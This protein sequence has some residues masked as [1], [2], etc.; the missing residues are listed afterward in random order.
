MKRF[1]AFLLIVVS[2]MPAVFAA[3]V[4]ICVSSVLLRSHFNST[5][6]TIG[7]T[8]K[9]LDDEEC[10]LASQFNQLV[11]VQIA[12]FAVVCSHEIC[13]ILNPADAAHVDDVW[14]RESAGRSPP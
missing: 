9:P 1:C 6:D 2:L 4:E 10:D 11:C 5:T 8:V 13:R 14:R 7:P 12:S 3:D